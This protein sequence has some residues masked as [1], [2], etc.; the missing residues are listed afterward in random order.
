MMQNKNSLRWV[1]PGT[2]R[3][4]FLGHRE[5]NLLFFTH[6]GQMQVTWMI[7][8]TIFSLRRM[9]RLSRTSY[10]LAKTAFKGHHAGKLSSVYLEAQSAVLP[11]YASILDPVGFRWKMESLLPRQCWSVLHADV[12]DRSHLRLRLHGERPNMYTDLCWLQDPSHTGECGSH[13]WWT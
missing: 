6:L 8:D 10:H 13:F 1:N 4:T 2:F 9:E 11:M 5:G 12:P 7:I 3:K